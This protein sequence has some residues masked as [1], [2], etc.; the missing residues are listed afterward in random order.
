MP[1]K[2]IIIGHNIGPNEHLRVL[3]KALHAFGRDIEH[4]TIESVT[5][6]LHDEYDTEVSIQNQLPRLQEI[7]LSKMDELA[8]HIALISAEIKREQKQEQKSFSYAQQKH[9]NRLQN[10]RMKAFKSRHR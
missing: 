9:Y 3:L 2:I 10:V 4:P 7:A 5:Q 6:I 1:N 8:K